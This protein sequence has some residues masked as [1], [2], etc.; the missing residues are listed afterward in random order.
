[1][2]LNTIF[3]FNRSV[4]HFT[5]K[6]STSWVLGW[7]GASLTSTDHF[8]AIRPRCAVNDRWSFANSQHIIFKKNKAFILLMYKCCVN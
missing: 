7:V 3:F 4:Q 8:K 1:M 5:L 2:L 6:R